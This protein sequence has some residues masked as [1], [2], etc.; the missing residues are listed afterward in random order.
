MKR[1]LFVVLVV[2]ALVTPWLLWQQ[3]KCANWRED[4][5]FYIGSPGSLITDDGQK[6]ETWTEAQ[7]RRSR[8]FLARDTK[9]LMCTLDPR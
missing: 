8:E 6:I 7:S 1:F 5:A 2:V 9:P 4:R 3:S